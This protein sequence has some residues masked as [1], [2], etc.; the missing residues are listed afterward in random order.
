MSVRLTVLDPMNATISNLDRT[1]ISTHAAVAHARAAA[2]P[3][4]S[5]GGS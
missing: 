4:A 5:H 1:A 2:G 3:G